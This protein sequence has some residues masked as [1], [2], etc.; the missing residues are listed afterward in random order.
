MCQTFKSLV[1]LL[2][3]NTDLEDLPAHGGPDLDR[4][5]LDAPDLVELFGWDEA[6]FLARTEGS[7]IRRLGHERW[8]RNVAVALGNG[9]ASDVALK[10]LH[11]RR[12]HAS[13]LVREHVAWALERLAIR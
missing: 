5:G 8:L 7:P 2:C 3:R 6:T 13:E 4:G 12:S 10:A 9:P 1:Q 11:A